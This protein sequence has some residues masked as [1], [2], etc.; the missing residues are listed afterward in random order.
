M[1][2]LK[3]TIVQTILH[4]ENPEENLKMFSELLKN[5]R[6]NSTDLIVLPEMFSTG[7]S[8]NAKNLAEDMKGASMQW[9][10]KVAS[11][12]NAAVCG[13]LI[14]K[15]RGKY[16]NRLIWMNP[17]GSFKKYDKRHLFR[18]GG[19]NH[20][21][22]AGAEKVII[23]FRDWKVLPLI[24]Y[25]LRFPVWSRNNESKKY[26]VLIYVA[27]WPMRRYFAWKQLLIARAIENQSYVIGANRIG[28]DGDLVEQAGGSAVISPMG[29]KISKTKPKQKSVEMVTLS[30][31]KLMEIRKAL[32]FLMDA[33]KIEIET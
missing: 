21:Y 27:N 18:I 32:P 8:M 16:F 5:V 12:K 7:F 26:D 29:E 11:E 13:S 6:K 33:D 25:D 3:V 4:W 24:C 2:N 9:M 30:A 14:I 1:R 10:K 17:D 15:E 31:K 20:T 28:A 19:E 23:E 22:T